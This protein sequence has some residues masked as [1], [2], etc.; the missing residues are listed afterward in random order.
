MEKGNVKIHDLKELMTAKQVA[1]IFGYNQSTILN[2]FKR[3]AAAIKKKYNVDLIRCEKDGKKYYQIFEETRALTIY[4]ETEDIMITQD[5]L[6]LEAF[7][8][9][10]SL[11][12]AASPQGVY[13]GRRTQ[14]LK[15]LGIKQDKK[16]IQKLDKV[17]GG[18]RTKGY[19]G[20]EQDQDFIIL[21]LKAKTER[22]CHIKIQMM[23]HCQRIADENHKSFTKIPQL[24]QVWKA[25]Q[26]C[27]ENQPFTYAD[28]ANLTGLSYG[29]IRDVRRLLERNDIFRTWRIG[30]YYHNEGSGVELN[31]FYD[32]DMKKK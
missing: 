9:F 24:I 6:S 23:Q 4:N 30:D 12:L 10:V 8:F 15:Y 19:I 16:N 29:Q 1:E 18:L 2:S 21:Y 3:A 7:Q 26:I 22:D 14:L 28:L 13:R 31:V 5:S 11:A 27:E 20:Y 17:I 25:V 32:N